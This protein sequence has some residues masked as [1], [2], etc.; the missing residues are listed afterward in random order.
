M[1]TRLGP[2]LA[3]PYEVG[4]AGRLAKAGKRVTAVGAAGFLLAG[5]SRPVSIVAGLLL[6][7]G[8]ACA[9][10]AVFE[11]GRQSARDPKYT[12]VQ[13]R[14]RLRARSRTSG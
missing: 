1:E 13:Q 4:V 12:V 2:L 5:R 9:R 8:S 7:T 3:E 6:L 11:A 10:F 14:E